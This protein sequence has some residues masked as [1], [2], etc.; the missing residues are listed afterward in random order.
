MPS[1]K[2]TRSE[3]ERMSVEELQRIDSDIPNNFDIPDDFDEECF[4]EILYPTV[5]SA[6]LIKQR[7]QIRENISS[8][9]PKLKTRF[10]DGGGI[11]EI[12]RIPVVFHNIYQSTEYDEN[13]VGIG[14]PIGSW[15]DYLDGLNYRDMRFTTGNDITICKQKMDLNIEALNRAFSDGGMQFELH[16][17]YQEVQNHSELGFNCL[18][19]KVTTSPQNSIATGY[20][21]PT[22]PYY[23]EVGDIT[24][25]CCPTEEIATGGGPIKTRYEVAGA[26]NIYIM[27][28]LLRWGNAGFAEAPGKVFIKIT[29]DNGAAL[30]ANPSRRDSSTLA[31]EVGHVF[32][33]AHINGKWY[34]SDDSGHQRDL[35][36]GSDCSINGD[37]IC[38]TPA[39]PGIVRVG[40][41][42]NA[43][44]VDAN[45]NCVYL[46]YGGEYDVDT[47]I[48]KLGGW[49]KNGGALYYLKNVLILIHLNL[50]LN[51]I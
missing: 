45:Y 41:A 20:N 26:L 11:T 43:W 44:Y 23:Y 49:N 51:V 38:D 12:I 3:L 42:T 8:I 13:G 40:G 36:D 14:E 31:H 39:E 37:L 25:G 10:Q 34:T 29:S 33:L 46:G 6:E 18:C 35:V 22:S 30:T 5:Y 32:G 1:R 24:P 2:Y 19:D 17:D 28:Q 27:M 7:K 9:L 4:S 48:L 21:D 50:L 47:G 16:P 15:C